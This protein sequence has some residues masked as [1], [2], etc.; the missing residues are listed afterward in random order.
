M[1]LLG[2]V[3]GY[4]VLVL[5][6]SSSS[7]NIISE[8]VAEK[9]DS[10]VQPMPPTTVKIADGG[11]LSCTCMLPKCEWKTQGHT[12]SSDMR[13]LS[14]GCFDI[15]VGMDWLEQCGPMWIDW[16]NKLLQFQHKGEGVLLTGI[17]PQLKTVPQVSGVQLKVMED[18]VDVLH[19]VVLCAITP[20]APAADQV[21][22]EVQTLL[23]EFQVVFMEP[24]ELPK[25]RD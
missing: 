13:V 15:V 22:P 18:V 10:K 12:F 5:V 25:Q 23:D 1:C 6:D 3:E 19:F 21:P 24:R 16:A 7:H 4:E 9:M 20:T 2:H 14:L 8:K 17:Q 11:T